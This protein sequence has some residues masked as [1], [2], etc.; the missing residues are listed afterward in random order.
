MPKSDSLILIWRKSMARIVSFLM[1]TSYCRPLRLSMIVSVSRLLP[2]E[3]PLFATV[4]DFVELMRWA[5]SGKF[6]ERTALPYAYHC[7][8]KPVCDERV[9]ARFPLKSDD[10]TYGC[11]RRGATRDAA[12][13][14][15]KDH[16]AKDF[17]TRRCQDFSEICSEGRSFASATPSEKPPANSHRLRP[18]A[19]ARWRA[20]SA[21]FNNS[22]AGMG[23]SAPLV[24]TPQ[25][26]VT[27]TRPVSVS[28]AGCSTAWRIR[29]ASA[30]EPGPSVAGAMIKNSSPP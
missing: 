7:T 1:G 13:P 12:G 20:S 27:E 30:S 15:A 3:A 17:Q 16:R 11:V 19:L 28:I 26:A 10:T 4:P 18:A 8:P 24:A 2:A 9:Y 25:L 21:N 14:T 22:F 29:S 5:L 6:D 23:F